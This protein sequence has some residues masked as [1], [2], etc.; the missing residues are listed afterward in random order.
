MKIP[1]ILRSP[2]SDGASLLIVS[3]K[4]EARLYL[5]QGV[6]INKIGEVKSRVPKYSDR[7]GFFEQRKGGKIIS[8]GSVYEP[9]DYVAIKKFV[10]LLEKE[11]IEIHR[12]Y[13]VSKV[14]LFLPLPQK[15]L[16]FQALPYAL[17]QKLALSIPGNFV[18][19]TPLNLL[20]LIKSRQERLPILRAEAAK[21]IDR[22]K[23][24]KRTAVKKP[25]SLKTV[26][27]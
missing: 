25:R 3:G 27:F 26:K 6:E 17:K 18:K 8:S 9:K 15:H 22:T 10:T 11:L 20:A 2:T 19:Q 24:A 23:Q 4:E 7:E 12:R 14:Y 1:K 5:T 16:I 21:I 13:N